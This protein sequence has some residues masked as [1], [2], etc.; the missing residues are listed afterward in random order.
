MTTVASLVDELLQEEKARSLSERSLGD[1]RRYLG[2]FSHWCDERGLGLKELTPQ[3]LLNYLQDKYSD[4]KFE[5]KK[6]M[7]WSLRKLGEFLSFHGYLPRNPAAGLKHPKKPKREKLPDYLSQAEMRQLLSHVSQQQNLLSLTV[8]SLFLN[9]GLRPGDLEEIT[10]FQ[11]FPKQ[12]YMAGLAKGAMRKHTPLS[13]TLIQ[14]LELYLASRTDRSKYLLVN[15]RG[16]QLKVHDLRE[17]VKK[18]AREA[19][20]KRTITPTLLRHTFATHLCDRHGSI[21][22]KALLGHGSHRNTQ[23]YVHLSPRRFRQCTNLHP[24][25]S[26]AHLH[27]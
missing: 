18:A 21:L 23:V 14:L 20:F 13:D 4:S 16:K 25:N 27:D 6:M 8:L 19:G 5:V 9:T 12:G 17:I 22:S 24:F 1:A 10:R 2:Y 3:L 26:E 15:E 11:F 7:I